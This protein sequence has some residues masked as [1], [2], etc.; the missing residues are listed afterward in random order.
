MVPS[1]TQAVD[2]S[3]VIEN[4]DT[5]GGTE[6]SDFVSIEVGIERANEVSVAGNSRSL[7]MAVSDASRI[8]KFQLMSVGTISQTY[9]RNWTYP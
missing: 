7:R 6:G 1:G 5:Q 2:E 8:G 9:L 3:D 4:G